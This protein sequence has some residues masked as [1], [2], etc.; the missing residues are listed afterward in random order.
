MYTK[1]NLQAS[2]DQN[3]LEFNLNYANLVPPLSLHNAHLLLL[4][5]KFGFYISFLTSADKT[6]QWHLC[7]LY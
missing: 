6:K 2:A 3:T 4:F 5:S 7:L 1:S